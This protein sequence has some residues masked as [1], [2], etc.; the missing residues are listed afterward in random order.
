MN[1]LL[2]SPK[3]DAFIVAPHLGLGYIAAALKKAGHRVKVLDGVR[4][5]IEYDPKEWDYVGVSA[6][7]TYWPEAIQ[8][9]KR[10]KSYGLKTVIGGAHVIACPE[11]S[12]RDSGA[13]YACLGE[14]EITWAQLA[15]G[16]PPEE[17]KGL[18]YWE[19][20][21]IRMSSPK[22][23]YANIDDFGMPDWQS[24]DPR[25]YPIAPHGMIARDYP[26]APIIT[27]RGCPYKCTYCSAPITAG[28]KMRFRNPIAVVDE[29]EMLVKD[30][31]VREIQIEDDNFTL[32]RSHAEAVCKEIINRKLKVLWSLPNG[33]RID[34]LDRDL[35]RL[36]RQSGCYLMALGI[37]SAN[38][39]ILDMV[40][41]QL[42]K[43]IVKKTV[44]EVVDADI[45]AWGFFMIGFP[46]ETKEE[47]ENTIK[48]ALELPLTRAQFTKATPLPGTDIYTLWREEYSKGKDIDWS[49]FN[50]YE[51]TA[52][53]SDISAEELAKLQKLGHMRFYLRPSR[54]LHM[55]RYMRPQQYALVLKRLLRMGRAGTVFDVQRQRAKL[56][57]AT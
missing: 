12:L 57:A 43:E 11:Q 42:N 55:V 7:S 39:R 35:V 38:Q 44:Q 33:V 13:D 14:G 54:F 25:T 45:E 23:F 4:E 16:M 30:Y 31:S 50:Y 49:T 24:I 10:A 5:N 28:E 41:K 26:L 52:D 8:E 6:M 1:I 46:T 32:R 2:I 47:I 22:S 56:E 21:Q 53:W 17:A 48:F 19:D 34:K 36:M 15:D 37:E 40:K 20:G 18:L 51:F 29:M 27:T 9:V 3:Y